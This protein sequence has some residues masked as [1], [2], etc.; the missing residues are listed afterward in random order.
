M[1]RERRKKYVATSVYIIKR[2]L[3]TMLFT[4]VVYSLYVYIRSKYRLTYLL[5]T[6]FHQSERISSLLR[7]TRHSIYIYIYI[8]SSLL[9]YYYPNRAM[10]I[11]I[12]IHPSLSFLLN[13][14]FFFHSLP[15]RCGVV[16]NCVLFIFTPRDEFRD[17]FK[18]YYYLII[19]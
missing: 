16:F 11:I 5:P 3:G 6:P 12:R 1:S 15:P 2:L 4:V 18:Y 19:V 9:L 10:I 14:L 8:L 17:P 13:L 7:D